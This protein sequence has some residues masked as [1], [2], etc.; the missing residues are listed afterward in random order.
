MK[1]FKTILR[2][3]VL[4]IILVL[5]LVTYNY[6]GLIKVIYF[7]RYGGEWITYHK[8]DRKTIQELYEL[9]KEKNEPT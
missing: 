6:W 8:D 9:L 2:F 5:V 4:P 3:I 1:T 7:I